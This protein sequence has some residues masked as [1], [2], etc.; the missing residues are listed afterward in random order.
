MKKLL[1]LLFC[2][3]ADSTFAQPEEVLSLMNEV[4]TNPQGFLQARLLPYLKENELEENAYAKS[5]VT[6]LT[7]AHKLEALQMSAA[8]TKTARSHAKDMG[9][10]GM[11][12]HNSSNGTSFP[13]RLRKKFK[14]GMIAE[15]CD[16]GNA[17]ALG[18]VMS[19]L[20]DDGISSLGHRRNILNPALKFVGIAIE[21]HKTYE[22]NC[23]MDFSQDN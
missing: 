18:I 21:P 10:H 5:L 2:F 7:S 16:Y 12:G 8:L 3:S 19:L 15:N 9:D 4:R 22:T 1:F 23:V 6:E 11:V 20:I 17:D 13:D 14:T